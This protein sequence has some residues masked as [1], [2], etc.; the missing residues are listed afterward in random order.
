MPQRL[1]LYNCRMSRLPGAIGLCTGDTV[2]IANAVN[3][4]QRRLLFAKEASDESWW[5]TWSEVRLNVSRVAPYITLPREIARLEAVT[6]CDRPIPVQNQFFEY[7]QF[8]N[9]RMSRGCNH[10]RSHWLRAAYT[11]NN[12]VLFTDLTTTQMIVLFATNPDDTAGNS[13]VLLQGLDQN[14]LRI[15]SMDG[16]NQIDGVFV[17]LAAPFASAPMQFSQ[18]T[19]VQKD[20]TKGPVQIFQ[21]DP[22]T[23]AQSILLTMEPGETTAS[24]RRYYFDHLPC[25]C[26]PPISHNPCITSNPALPPPQVTA[27]AKLDLI[28]VVTDT[29]YLLFQ[30]LEAVIEECISARMSEMDSTAAQGLATTHH[31]NAIRLLNGELGHFNGVNSPAVGFSPFGSARL[32]HQRI[33]TMI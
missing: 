6:V 33:G 18:I 25:S 10:R 1:R 8:G 5:G 21:Q 24:Y 22:T 31:T 17:T 14:G 16:P 30:N 26:A 32:E 4:A 15:Y 23:A 27:I 13:R 28:P 20:V 19:G 2:A 12:A 11:R 29:D 3:T 7:I 9:G